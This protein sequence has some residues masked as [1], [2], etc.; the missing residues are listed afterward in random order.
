[1]LLLGLQEGQAA[2]RPGGGHGHA[3]PPDPPPRISRPSA[4]PARP[5]PP[6]P[7]APRPSHSPPAPARA[8]DD[9]P[10]LTPD[11]EVLRLAGPE[12]SGRV[13]FWLSNWL[14]WEPEEEVIDTAP[15]PPQCR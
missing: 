11:P 1:M 9:A 6:A 14:T 12:V 4:A 8:R 3:W 10:L 15:P 7:G 5:S 13:E 2:P